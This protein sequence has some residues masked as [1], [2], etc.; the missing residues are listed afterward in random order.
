MR[1]FGDVAVGCVDHDC[2]F[3]SHL[4]GIGVWVSY[5]REDWSS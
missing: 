2:D 4:Y 1:T 3:G 5:W